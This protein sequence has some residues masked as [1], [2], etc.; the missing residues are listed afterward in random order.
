MLPFSS[1][2]MILRDYHKDLSDFE[3]VFN[4]TSDPLVAKHSS[5]GHLTEDETLDF[6]KTSIEEAEEVPRATYQLAILLKT[7]Q[8]LIGNASLHIDE[9][10]TLGEIGYTFRRD[11]WNQGLGTEV[12]MALIEFGMDTLCL[13]K[14]T[15]TVAPEN[16]A[17]QRVLEK[18]GMKKMGFISN[19]F[20]LRGTWRDSLTYA[21]TR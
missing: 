19:H 20:N 3:S 18:A 13:P 14:M 8:E 16:L 5:W 11:Q 2:R 6:L 21:Y 10:S 17:S 9:F 12:A 15:A 7:T 4:F 1:P